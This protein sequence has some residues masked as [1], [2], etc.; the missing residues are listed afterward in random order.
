MYL[1]SL[2]AKNDNSVPKPYTFLGS[3]TLN[4]VLSISLELTPIVP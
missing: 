2:L 4:V 3:T 1:W